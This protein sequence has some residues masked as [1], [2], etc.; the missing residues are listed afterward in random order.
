MY[1]IPPDLEGFLRGLF[2]GMIG[3]AKRLVGDAVFLF[4]RGSYPS[5]QFLAM[6]A[7]EEMARLQEMRRPFIILRKK[8]DLD[9]ALAHLESCLAEHR[10][11]QTTAFQAAPYAQIENPKEWAHVV[12][13]VTRLV[14]TRGRQEILKTRLRSLMMDADVSAKTVSKPAAVTR[15]D[16]YYFICAAHEMI[17][18]YGDKG[19]NPFPLAAGDPSEGFDLWQWADRAEKEFQR[20]YAHC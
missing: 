16:A 13:M 17:A 18:D 11:R 7:M 15:Q 10:E 8:E 4:E 6:S 19:L 1:E 9:D 14:R 20:K 12:D 2:R 5:A 3:N